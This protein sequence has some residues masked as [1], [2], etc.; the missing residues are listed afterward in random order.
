MAKITTGYNFG[1]TAQMVQAAQ[2]LADGHNLNDIIMVLW[3]VSKESDRATYERGYR[4]LKKWQADENFQKL[5]AAILKESTLP[6]VGRAIYRIGQQIDDS[7][8]WVAQGAAREVLARF[9]GAILGEE[10]KSMTVRVEG[11]PT[12]GVPPQEDE[13]DS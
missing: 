9:G 6:L 8:P 5:H 12:I 3:G 2:L 4:K 13:D 10:E 1:C 11:M 7:N